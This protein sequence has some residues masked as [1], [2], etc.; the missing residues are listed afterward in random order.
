[1]I[2]SVHQHQPNDVLESFLSMKWASLHP[3]EA[4]DPCLARLGCMLDLREWALFQE[5]V[6]V[7]LVYLTS[8]DTYL[9]KTPSAS[10]ST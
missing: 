8:D 7:P 10:D 3:D 4:F 9:N 6:S 2:V 5:V 1:M